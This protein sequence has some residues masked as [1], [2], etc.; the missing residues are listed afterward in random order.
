MHTKASR[1]RGL[2][3]NLGSLFW[4]TVVRAKPS[5]I[6]ALLSVHVSNTFGTALGKSGPEFISWDTPPPLPIIP[7]CLDSSRNMSLLSSC[8]TQKLIKR[9]CMQLYTPLPAYLVPPVTTRE[10][11]QNITLIP[12]LKLRDWGISSFLPNLTLNSGL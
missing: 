10:V 3:S 11:T 1:G 5:T 6:P 9:L 12:N 4:Q 8:A 7:K 2:F